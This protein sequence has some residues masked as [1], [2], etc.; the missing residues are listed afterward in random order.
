MSMITPLKTSKEC[1][2]TLMNL[3]EKKAPTQK[4][5][6]KNQLCSMNMEKD[7]TVAYFFT[8]IS[9]VKDQQASISVETSE[10]DILQTAIDGLPTS[11]ETFLATVNGREEKPNFERL[12]NDIFQEEG[13][14]QNKT[15]HTKE[16]NLALMARTKK[17]SKPFAPKKFFHSKQKEITKNFEK[18]K[19]K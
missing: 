17:G 19:F 12:Q 16:E 4:R 14:I 5:D 9:Q 7:E 6:L 3:Y 18:S 11:W 10:D 2:D 1:F 8:N 13:H 15:V